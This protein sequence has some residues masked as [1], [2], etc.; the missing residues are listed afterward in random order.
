[1]SY[2][3]YRDN[4]DI[5]DSDAF[6]DS[7]VRA[8]IYTFSELIDMSSQRGRHNDACACDEGDAC[9]SWF[10]IEAGSEETIAWLV[11]KGF[12]DMNVL[13]SVLAAQEE[14]SE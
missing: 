6:D 1:M 5:S 8:E 13:R 9:S 3:C 7:D 11:A 10:Y 2:Y 12:I 4:S 14:T